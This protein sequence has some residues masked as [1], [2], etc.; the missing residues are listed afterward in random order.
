MAERLKDKILDADKKVDVVCG[1]D[2]YRDLPRL[3]EEVDYGQK[4]IN[5]ILSLEETYADI[6][7]VAIS[8]NSIAAFRQITSCCINCERGSRALERRHERAHLGLK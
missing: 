4:A 3:L 5:T 7:P 8:K 1:L 2:A 6:S